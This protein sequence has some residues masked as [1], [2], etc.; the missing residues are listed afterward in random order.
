MYTVIV[1][2]GDKYPEE[3]IKLWKK[4]IPDVKVLGEDAPFNYGWQ[5]WS[6]KFELFSPEFKFRPCLYL[7]LDTYILGDISEFYEE[8]ERLMLIRDFNK[9]N[10]GNS[11]VMQIPEDT[12]S[13]WESVKGL[14]NVPDG[15]ALNQLPHGYLQDKYPG[16]IVSYKNDNCKDKRP[17]SPIMCFHG[18]PKPHTA[19][20]WA[21]EL[22]KTYTT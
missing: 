15:D 9:P 18:K 1:R 2:H 6:S 20:G 4:F 21:G 22:W 3:Y 16:K 11:G 12:S 13:I 7:D 8:P 5:G 14:G 19:E 17:D 10:R